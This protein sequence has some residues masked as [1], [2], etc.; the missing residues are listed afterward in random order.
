MLDVK[1]ITMKQ[2]LPSSQKSTDYLYQ[3]FWRSFWT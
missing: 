1:S 3:T 2:K